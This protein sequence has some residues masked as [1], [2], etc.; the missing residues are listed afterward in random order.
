MSDKEKAVY[1]RIDKVLGFDILS[2][3]K[4]FGMIEFGD[5]VY[6]AT[7]KRRM[8]QLYTDLD[9]NTVSSSLMLITS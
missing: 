9:R 7:D 1:S 3:F 6:S 5:Y 4:R 8:L 2:N